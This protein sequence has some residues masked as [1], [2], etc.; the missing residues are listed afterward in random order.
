MS[1]EVALV[2]VLVF[3]MI[4]IGGLSAAYQTSVQESQPTQHVI[5]ESFYPVNDS[6][7]VLDESRRDV[8][9]NGSD[10]V[11]VYQNRTRYNS[12]GNWTWRAGDGTL[13]VNETS[14]F[15]ESRLANISYNYTAPVAAQQTARDVA[16]V[17]YLLGDGLGIVVGAG[18]IIGAIALLGRQA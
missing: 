4:A 16:L 5:N 17:P 1:R 2:G 8:V 9:Y 13:Y 14:A 11:R 12:T 15:N 6:V 18:L 10:D 3:A 7:V